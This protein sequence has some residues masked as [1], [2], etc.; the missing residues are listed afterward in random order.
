MDEGEGGDGG[1]REARAEWDVAQTVVSLSFS[2]DSSE[3][4]LEH[5]TA[6]RPF[7]ENS[8]I[9][10]LANSSS[11]WTTARAKAVTGLDR[12]SFGKWIRRTTDRAA[13]V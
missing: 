1:G 6:I 2:L 12:S 11:P 10:L 13:G 5:P 8:L 3:S 4:H 9:L 7:P